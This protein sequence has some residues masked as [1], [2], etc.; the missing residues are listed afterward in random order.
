MPVGHSW[1]LMEWAR[2]LGIRR[3]DQ[4]DVSHIVQP[5]S[6][7]GDHSGFTSQILPP[8]AWLGGIRTAVAAVFSTFQLTSRAPGGTYVRILE[9]HVG[10]AKTSQWRIG[11]TVTTLAN[12]VAN[13]EKYDFGGSP[14]QSICVMGT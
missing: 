9:A 1:N 12:V 7:V 8:M 11:P 5:V 14:T 13:L 6:I 10:A 4:P 2:A 3:A